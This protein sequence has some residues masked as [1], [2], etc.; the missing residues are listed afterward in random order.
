VDGLGEISPAHL[1][2][3]LGSAFL[4]TAVTGMLLAQVLGLP[5]LLG[6]DDRW[7]LVLLA[8]LPP[9]ALQILLLR[10]SL[11]ESPRWL[12]LRGRDEAARTTLARLRGCRGGEVE[13]AELHQE[14][15]SMLPSPQGRPGGRRPAS[16]PGGGSSARLLIDP[17]A[18]RPLVLCVGLMA[19][20]QFSG[21]NNVFNYSSTFLAQR[22]LSQQ[23]CELVALL[24]NSVNVFVVL[25]STALMDRLGR[26]PLLA[27]SLGG[28]AA[29][30]LLLTAALLLGSVPLVV[31][32]MVLFV[33]TFGVG[34]GPVVWL[35]PAELFP[36]QLRASAIATTTVVNWLAN[37]VVGQLF[38]PLA[39]W[40]G[41]LSFLP[42]AAVL[43]AG[44][45]L[46]FSLP[47]TR[48]RTLEEIEAYFAP[49]LKRGHSITAPLMPAAAWRGA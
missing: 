7:R 47:E 32:A 35:L 3:T 6:S 22:G 42:F 23:E 28:M 37:Y 15:A 5:P 40:L 41:P 26:K 48:G 27:A 2:G 45:L 11:L 9:A 36:T 16:W 19:V 30:S 29:A 49:R 38:L 44:L 43:A 34:L 13:T 31:V 8:V 33:L 46:A 24:M 20:Q 12:L 39:S 17:S 1:R 4:L 14:L 18:R 25:L 10:H 21:I